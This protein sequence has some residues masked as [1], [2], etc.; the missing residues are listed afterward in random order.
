MSLPK[1]KEK[2]TMHTTMSPSHPE[3][4]PPLFRQTTPYPTSRVDS[5]EPP[6]LGPGSDPLPLIDLTCMSHEGRLSEACKD[7]GIFRL[8]NHGV[9]LTLLN[10]LHEHAKRVF[11]LD[12]ASKQGI[13]KSP[14][15]YFWGTPALTPNGLAL[16]R[17]AQNFNWVEGLNIPLTQLSML[18]AQEDPLLDSFR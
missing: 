1:Q 13:F 11:N 17:G 10:Q 16:Q 6:E 7:W 14:L 12:F 8:V 5:V 18:Q 9:P 3:T 15:S 4:Y 2:K